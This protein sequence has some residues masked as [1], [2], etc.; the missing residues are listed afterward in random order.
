MRQLHLYPNFEP[1]KHDHKFT[2]IFFSK[3]G[4]G[5]PWLST[6]MTPWSGHATGCPKKRKEWVTTF[7]CCAS[8]LTSP[9]KK[10]LDGYQKNPDAKASHEVHNFPPQCALWFFLGC[11]CVFRVFLWS[12]HVPC[13][14]SSVCFTL[15]SL[16]VG[17]FYKVVIFFK[18]WFA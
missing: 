3:F 11:I 1:L 7:Y 2:L 18:K 10:F 14:L 13:L 15:H 4:L 9:N 5:E 16:Q 8:T 12:Y 17:P 6:A